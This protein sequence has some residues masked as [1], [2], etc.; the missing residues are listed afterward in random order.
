MLKKWFGREQRKQHRTQIESPSLDSFSICLEL[1]DQESLPGKIRNISV[2]SASVSFPSEQCPELDPGDKVILT[3][4][5]AQLQ[6][7]IHLN[8]RIQECIPEGHATTISF[9]FEDS[10]RFNARLDASHLS[11]LNARQSYRVEV[12]DSRHH[13][14]VSWPGPA[15]RR[16][17]G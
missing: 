11:F 2:T 14:E 4:T 10:S 1:A 13:T 5:V 7:I 15:A 6:E 3:V 9:I 12:A 16:W 17:A 8:G